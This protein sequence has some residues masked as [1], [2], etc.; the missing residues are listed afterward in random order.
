MYV[1]SLT[2]FCIENIIL[3]MYVGLQ[4]GPMYLFNMGQNYYLPWYVDRSVNNVLIC[5][6]VGYWSLQ[7]PIV[8]FIFYL[9]MIFLFLH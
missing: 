7:K 5:V 2:S 8:M 1:C 3:Y 9:L 6:R 4:W